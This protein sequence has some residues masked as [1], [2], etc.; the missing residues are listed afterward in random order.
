ML[1][2]SFG[3]TYVVSGSA[4]DKVLV[5]SLLADEDELFVVC[6]VQL[7]RRRASERKQSRRMFLS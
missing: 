3:L 2:P 4:E 1:Y 6:A 5:E 7:Q